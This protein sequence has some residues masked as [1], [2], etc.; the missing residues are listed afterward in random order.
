MAARSVSEISFDRLHRLSS[1]RCTYRD[2][3]R[4]SDWGWT[5][6]KR[7]HSAGRC[8][9]PN[10]RRSA[11]ARVRDLLRMAEAEIEEESTLVFD[12]CANTGQL[13][14]NV[15]HMTWFKREVMRVLQEGL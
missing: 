11:R 15:A 14:G 7:H 6:C 12:I 9:A 8:T 4:H 5:T 10:E 2:C 13:F 1:S 3:E